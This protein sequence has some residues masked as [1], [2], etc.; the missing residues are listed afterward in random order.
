MNSRKNIQNR[1]NFFNILLQESFEFCVC[2]NLQHYESL[3]LPRRSS[4]SKMF[5]RFGSSKTISII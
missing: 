5:S 1:F 4:V 2:R 3:F